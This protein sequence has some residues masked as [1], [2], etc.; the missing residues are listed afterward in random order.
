MRENQLWAIVL[1]GGE[2]TR[3]TETTQR[4]YGS[5]LPKQ[6]LSFGRQRTFLQATVERIAPLIPPE[7]TIVV[8]SSRY[9]E[10]A[11]EQLAEHDGIEIVAQ[12]RNVGTGAGVLLPLVHLLRRAADS[13]VALIP[14]DH[15][16]RSPAV[17]LESLVRAERATAAGNAKMVLLGARAEAPSADLGWIV[18]R[19]ARAAG[20]VRIIQR[21]VEK[22]PQ[23]LADALYRKGA[24]WNT[25]LSV[26]RAAE[27]WQLA[28][29]LL[30]QQAAL[31]D[32]YA[33]ALEADTAAGEL[34]AV[35]E[36]LAPSD[37]SRDLVGRALGLRVAE[38]AGAGWNDCG[39]PERLAAVFGAGLFAPARAAA[40]RPAAERRLA[41]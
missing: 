16:F 34:A 28:R 37:F 20:A 21:F 40:P 3:L 4:L 36:R 9:E 29:L 35:Y 33:S 15:D 18:A 26:S 27:L 17:M 13:S 6:F 7:R 5:G 38:M 11:R 19:R 25:M 10:L 23:P 2:G 30:P 14:S 22:P 31:F 41:V 39:T 32:R 12:P 24:L 8:V 1:A